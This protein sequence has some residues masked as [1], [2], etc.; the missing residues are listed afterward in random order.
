MKKF[1]AVFLLVIFSTVLTLAAS[2][3]IVRIFCPQPF[4]S[5]FATS[6]EKWQKG[7]NDWFSGKN[8]ITFS[9]KMGID[10]P[11]GLFDRKHNLEKRPD[12]FRILV[13]GDSV[14]VHGNPPYPLMFEDLLNKNS[15][16][17]KYEV[18]NLAVPTYNTFQEK[19]YFK[20]KGIKLDPDMIIIGFCLNDFAPSYI[21]LKVKG[22]TVLCQ[23]HDEVW[24]GISPFLFTH[25][26][27]YRLVINRIMDS[28]AR[29]LARIDEKKLKKETA[30][31]RDLSLRYYQI[32]YDSMKYFK[33]VSC[34]RKIPLLV[35]VFPILKDEGKYTPYERDAYAAILDMCK[36]FDI[37]YLD[38]KP[39]FEEIGK[40]DDFRYLQ[41]E[42]DYFHFNNKGHALVADSIFD[43]FNSLNGGLYARSRIDQSD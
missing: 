27:L 43:Y 35:L 39:Y 7:D 10:C 31:Y 29:F 40:W 38:L 18:W 26:H 24:I 23:A 25:S 9:R 8:A 6:S 42:S 16:G 14:T 32:V 15:K 3:L 4:F 12:T 21:A 28:R 5:F 11:V 22:M 41:R 20:E 1:F 2:E 13:L 30:R 17:K 36:E 34:E 37:A 19:E 33:A